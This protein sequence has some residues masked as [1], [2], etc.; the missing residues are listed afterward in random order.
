MFGRTVQAACAVL[1]LGAGLALGQKARV[2][3]EVNG[4]A[5]TADEVEAELRLSPMAVPSTDAQRKLR[6][7][8]ALGLLIDNAL[9]RQFL[10]KTVG[11]AAPDLVA[12]RLAEL[13]AGLKEKNS[14]LAEFLQDSCQTL[15]QLKGDLADLSRWN[16]Y[17]ASLLDDKALEQ[18]HRDNK[19]FFDKTTM[20]AS[21]IVLRVP[22]SAPK[23]EHDKA[24][25]HLEKLRMHLKSNPEQFAELAKKHSQDGNAL[26]GGDV[27]WFPRKWAFDEE[28][29]AA[30]FAMP[31][32]GLSEVVKTEYGYHLILATDR[33][34]GEPT[35]FQD[36]KESVRAFCSEDLRQRVL[37][38]ERKKASIKIMLP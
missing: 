6:H 36:V 27:G 17:A 38:Q 18:Y 34:E 8:E 19:E 1:A 15:E 29:A 28:F 35:R 37:A 2:A 12:K 24:K 3:A 31:K 13:E 5:I 20:R 7:M 30:A 33:K 14:T 4:V 25:E 11:P 22:A 21:H 16:G 23:A 32:G 10:D 26:A 9:M